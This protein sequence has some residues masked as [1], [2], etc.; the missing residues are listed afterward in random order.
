MAMLLEPQIIA[1]TWGDR[2]RPSDGSPPRD[3]PFWPEAIAAVRRRHPGFTFIAEV[4]WDME[5][6][7]QQAGFDFTYDKRLYDRLVAGDATPV[8]EHLWADGAFQDRSV[9]FLENHDEPRAATAFP[10][11]RHEAAAIVAFTARGLRFFHEGQLEGRRAQVSMHVGRRPAEPVDARLQAFY[12]R[13]LTVLRRPELH[14]GAWRL[15]TC[16]PAWDGNPTH[17]QFVVSSW[18]AGE[19]RLLVAVN[20]G[21]S[22]A[23]TYATVGMSGLGGRALTLVDL[24]SDA[25][26]QRAGD[27]LVGAGLY[28]DLPPWG[29][30]IFDVVG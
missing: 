17:Q 10:P 21:P 25:R 24:M 22:Q 12:A 30:N 16:R 11:G 29:Y 15:A 20:Y 9:R 13:L 8:R 27:D 26:Y 4:Y 6:E 3:T 2:A 23:Q 5:W 1:K 7:L 28:L 18:Q 19:R 14:E